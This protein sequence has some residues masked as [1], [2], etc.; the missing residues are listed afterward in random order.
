MQTDT[1]NISS[2]LEAIESLIRGSGLPNLSHTMNEI[3]QQVSEL[4]QAYQDRDN[5]IHQLQNELSDQRN[6][7]ALLRSQTG[8]LIQLEQQMT[9]LFGSNQSSQS[10]Q[11]YLAPP[12]VISAGNKGKGAATRYVSF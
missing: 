4:K 3:H 5:I 8:K 12:A 11:P 6:E 2:R 1:A 10:T 9:T 7:I